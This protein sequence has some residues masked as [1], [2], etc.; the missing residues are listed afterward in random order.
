[1]K[2][3]TPGDDGQSQTCKTIP[4]CILESFDADDADGAD[5]VE[6]ADIDPDLDATRSPS[7][8]S[9]DTPID[10]DPVATRPPSTPSVE[11]NAPLAPMDPDPVATQPPPKPPL[12]RNT[13]LLIRRS[14]IGGRAEPSDQ[15]LEYALED[16]IG[17]G[18]CGLVYGACQKTIDRQV[19]IK[20]IRPELAQD[21]Q[22]K[23]LFLSEAVVTGDLDHPNIVP[24]YDLGVDQHEC[25]FYSMKKIKGVSWKKVIAEKSQ[26]E[27]VEILLRVCDAMAF[28][29]DK[30]VIHRDLKP[31]NIMLGDYGEVFVMD[32]G[33]A[34]SPGGCGKAEALT[35]GS[36]Q[37]GTPA[38]MAPEM[39]VADAGRVNHLSDIY[40][41]GG[42]LYEIETG[43]VPHAGRDLKD[44]I[45]KAAE[46]V[47]QPTKK[48]SELIDIALRAMSTKPSDRYQSVSEFSQAI[49]D[50][51][52]HAESIVLCKSATESHARARKS[53]VYQ[54]YLMALFSYDNA[55]K[56]WPGNPQAL[57][58]KSEVQLDYARAAFE[59]ND[60][61]LA[62]SLLD[63]GNETH[64]GLLGKVLT[65]RQDRQSHHRRIQWLKF[66]ASSLALLTLAVVSIGLV[67]VK[68]QRDRAVA[69]EKSMKVAQLEALQEYYYSGIALASRKL[70]D[71][72][73]AQ[74][75]ALLEKLPEEMRGWEW[76]RLERL[77]QMDLTTFKGHGESIV[78]VAFSPDE[79]FIATGDRANGIKVWNFTG[80]EAIDSYAN[81]TSPGRIAD[82]RFSADGR[83]VVAQF[84]DGSMLSREIGG[85]TVNRTAYRPTDNDVL[86][87]YSPEQAYF[88][89]RTLE[90]T[91]VIQ[92]TKDNQTVSRLMGHSDSIYT[93]AFS[94]DST[95][96][97]TGSADNSAIVWDLASGKSLVALKGHSGSVQAVK[98]SPTGRYILTGSADNTAKLWSAEVNR[99]QKRF[100]G[101]QSFVS[102]V[103]FSP[104]SRKLATSSHDGTIKIWEIAGQK[105]ERTLAGHA[106]RVYAV[107]FSPDGHALLSGGADNQAIL[108]NADTGAIISALR[109]HTHSITS[110]DFSPDG[111]LAATGSWDHT[112]KIWDLKTLREKVTLEGHAGPVISVCFSPDNRSLVSGGKDHGARIW[113]LAGG[114]TAR[115]LNGHSAAVYSVAF[116]QDGKYIATASWD[117]SIKVWD[118]ATGEL[119]R[120]LIG[121]TASVYAAVFVDNQRR[122]ISAGWDKSVKIWDTHSGQELMELAGLSAPIYALRVSPDG[123]MAAA[124]G[125]DNT[126]VIWQVDAPERIQPSRAP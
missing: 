27:N 97:A 102:G 28:A 90:N 54:D 70:S 99:D 63:A 46:N 64:Q 61:D 50:Y 68:T 53:K 119:Q 89:K 23:A 81:P 38:Y 85:G 24:V 3:R 72:H 105:E 69:A 125:R 26:A 34:A 62:I 118:A 30:G 18:A 77:C 42:L 16:K 112:I 13:P 114:R 17:E 45:R 35:S 92:R 121:H 71:Q 107:Q 10:P 120:T 29:H 116:S 8:P 73:Y 47:I 37:A 96:V 9:V 51:R 108:W 87:F 104:D 126:A 58:A 80:G 66:S 25:L 67:V 7:T 19:A 94:P 110:V 111:G 113:D 82:L 4:T 33:I 74:A 101:H 59:K 2:K 60:Y 75:Q 55:M 39:A 65:A 103:A 100:S 22:I 93:A 11:R 5:D 56:I 49:R 57:S 48:S 6:G 12:E 76:R 41:L 106:G 84:T 40:L 44:C 1:M 117:K 21:Q 15:L 88:I 95:K 83:Q 109:G 78:A 124:G 20:V 31:Q 36:N 122:I 98:F 14:R 79:R 52:S 91:A 115:E 86:M 32:W 43:V 123:R